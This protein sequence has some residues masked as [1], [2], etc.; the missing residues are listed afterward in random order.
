MCLIAIAPEGKDK[1][2]E[3]FLDGL[4]LAQ[5]ENSDGIGYAYKKFGENGIYYNKGRNKK[6]LDVIAELKSFNL[7]EKDELIVHLR[8]TTSV[9]DDKNCHPYILTAVDEAIDGVGYTKGFRPAL[10]HN[11]YFTNFVD[12]SKDHSDT[13][14]FTR[15][16]MRNPDLIKLL[17]KDK[18]TF[19]HCFGSIIKSNKLAFIF[20]ETANK[21]ITIGDFIEENGYIF[22]NFSYRTNKVDTRKSSP[23]TGFNIPVVNKIKELDKFQERLDK[24]I[25]PVQNLRDVGKTPEV[26]VSNDNFLE[27]M[28]EA[29]IDFPEMGIKKDSKWILQSFGEKKDM[30]MIHNWENE[31]IFAWVSYEDLY[32]YFIARPKLVFKAKYT[33]Y[34]RLKMLI[35]PTKSAFKKI[36]NRLGRIIGKKKAYP[37]PSDLITIP[38][39]NR[40]IDNLR[41][42]AI[43]MFLVEY[44]KFCNSPLNIPTSYKD[45]KEVVVSADTDISKEAQRI[46]DEV[47]AK[48]ETARK[49]REA[50]MIKVTNK[51]NEDKEPLTDIE[52]N[53]E[54]AKNAIEVFKR[55]REKELKEQ[56]VD[57]H[58]SENKE[59][60][61]IDNDYL[62]NKLEGE[63]EIEYLTRIGLARCN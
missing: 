35:T 11:G 34:Y 52:Q 41:Y 51:L 23:I 45:K 8:R 24:I 42:D 14:M 38:Y 44:S 19:M 33:D 59:F 18:D 39:R 49:R 15:L 13:Y 28:L 16:F 37:A 58:I 27:V 30:Q 57:N 7:T 26:I 6:I 63:S 4:V 21:I 60:S 20:P 61:F 29:S 12:P 50:V 5:K 54:N 3:W 10:F 47:T 56:L 22:S 62:D 48:I 36:N 53:A 46:N 55:K 43:C 17:Q 1:Y 40:E 31:A 25:N 9:K 2:N 32:L